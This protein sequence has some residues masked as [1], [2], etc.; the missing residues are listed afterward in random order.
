MEIHGKYKLLFLLG[1]GKFGKV[2]KAIEIVKSNVLIMVAIKMEDTKKGLLKHET[3]MLHYL[4]NKKCLNV[5]NIIWFGIESNIPCLII[6]FYPY[7]FIEYI[8]KYPLIDEI[9]IMNIM[10]KIM[11]GIHNMDV[12]HRDIK[13]DNFMMTENYQLIL[14]D[15]GL[16]VFIKNNEL[17]EKDGDGITITGNTLFASPNVHKMYNS[18]KID[19]IISI[20]YIGLFICLKLTLP[21][22]NK[23]NINYLYLK[24]KDYLHL[25]RNSNTNRIIDFICK[26]YDNKLLYVY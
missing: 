15:F 22:N 2:F 5:P 13:P 16:S 7:S 6:P 26:L 18:R 11:K 9:V 25:L 24:S 17:K 21:W 20:A 3:T 23:E 1:E 8:T 4:N 10:L 14:I 19:D 12:I